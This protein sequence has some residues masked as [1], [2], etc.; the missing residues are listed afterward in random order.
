MLGMGQGLR[1]DEMTRKKSTHF[2]QDMETWV[3][4]K[5]GPPPQLLILSEEAFLSSPE[6]SW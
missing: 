5:A 2:E 3:L 6:G 1:R 4:R